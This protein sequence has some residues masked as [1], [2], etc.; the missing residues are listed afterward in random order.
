MRWK[1]IIANAGIVLIVGLLAFSLLSTSL[2][3]L[4]S[5]PTNRKAA[6]AQ[7]ARSANARLA[8]DTVQLE[9]WLAER[10]RA[11]NVRDVFAAGTAQARQENATL[12]ASRIR[13][14]AVQA[15]ALSGL[16]PTLVLFIDEQGVALG[17]NGSA[18]MRG[19]KIS[20]VYPSLTQCLTTGNTLS[21]LWISRQRQEQMFVSVAPVRGDQGAIVGAVIVGVPLNDERFQRISDLTSG[22][23]LLFSVVRDN[24]LDVVARGG[25]SLGGEVLAEV[26]GAKLLPA[27]Q[28]ALKGRNVATGDVAGD[29]IF[30]VSPLDGFA[31]SQAVIVAVLSTSLVPSVAGLLAPLVYA[32]ALGIV[33]VIVA[34]WLLGN[35]ITQPVS[36]LEDGLLA[37]ING[38]ETLRFQIEHPELGGLVFRINSLLNAL[39]GV[40]EDNTDEQG[41]PSVSPNAQHFEEA[42]SVDESSVT[43]PQVSP[44]VIAMLSKE[45]E[46]AYYA[47]VYRDY[48]AARR[49]LG[50]PVEGI[51]FDGFIAHIRA[52]EQEV[53]AKHG[54]SVRY[55]VE[56]R[57]NS[58]VLIAVPMPPP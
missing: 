8:L 35:Y 47:R 27:A 42:L 41:R 25:P 17:R 48:V 23:G 10:V 1:I 49:Q 6:A 52:S 56:V 32:I 54:R 38:N 28:L 39:M 43:N 16:A 44:D 19:E 55:L 45:S 34:G 4:V 3:D 40:P 18:L 26:T 7:A 21:D 33:L 11:Q 29:S 57:G 46:E 36:E 22:S 37:V 53:A 20:A 24:G 15:A 50:D 14:D 12:Q 51:S 2:T 9:R 58:V 31:S 30:A 13:D 5:N